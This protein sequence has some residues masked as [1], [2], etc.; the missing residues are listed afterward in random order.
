VGTLLAPDDFV[1][2]RTPGK[3]TAVRDLQQCTDDELQELAAA[4]VGSKKKAIAAEIL[5]RRR[6]ERWQQWLSR[7]AALAAL[8]GVVMAGLVALRRLFGKRE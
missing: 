7:N 1:I 8:V 3:K 5:R 2:R 4:E 6:R